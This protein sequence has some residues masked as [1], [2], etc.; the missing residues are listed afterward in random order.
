MERKHRPLREK[1]SHAG[2]S[3][4]DRKSSDGRAY[5]VAEETLP[6]TLHERIELSS[7][8][9]HCASLLRSLR[10]FKRRQCYPTNNVSPPFFFNAE[11]YG[12]SVLR[13]Y[14]VKSRATSF[15]PTLDSTTSH[16]SSPPGL[17]NA[18]C[19]QL[20]SVDRQLLRYIQMHLQR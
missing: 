7:S 4:R 1:A 20:R 5:K 2:Q 10:P 18:W 12:A 17:Q 16:L 6:R 9:P 15:P 14:F 11:L 19:S 13:D 8:E 3:K